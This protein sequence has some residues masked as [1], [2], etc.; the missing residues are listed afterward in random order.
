[1]MPNQTS[2]LSRTVFRRAALAAVT[3]AAVTVTGLGLEPARGPD[4]RSP[5]PVAVG[6]PVQTEAEALTVARQSG[7]QVEV[8]GMRTERREILAAPDGTFTAREYTEPVHA[9]QGGTWVDVDKTLVKRKDGSVAPKA[10]TVGLVFSGGEAGKPFVTMRRG[11]HEMALTWPYGKLTAPVLDG[12]TATYADALPGVDL[13]VRAESDGFGHLLVVK[14][15]EAAADPRLN[16]LDLGLKAK[17][18]TYKKD[19]AGALTAEDSAVGGTV[20]Q[21]GRATMW[22]S[23]GVAETKAVG[24]GATVGGKGPKAAADAVSA[25]RADAPAGKTAPQA[26]EPALAGPEGGGRA[27]DIGVELSKDKLTLIPDQNLLKDGATVFPVVI[28]PIA[29]TLNRSSWTAV[30]SG[31]PDFGEYRYGGS[32]GVGLCPIN[33]NHATCDG[34]GKRRVMYEMPLS[35]Y[36]GKQILGATFSARVEHVYWADAK[37]EPIQ[38]YRVGDGNSHVVS[39]S[40]WRNSESVWSTHLGTVNEK[41]Q[42]TSCGSQANLHF[43]S[44]AN[45]ALA[46]D[47]RSALNQGWDS[48]ILGLKAQD[49]TDYPGW[50]R[51]CGN[52]Y[53]TMSYNNLPGKIQPAQMNSNPGG[54]CVVGAG[55]P[56]VDSAPRLEAIANDRDHAGGQTDQVAVRFTVRYIEGG[57]GKQYTYTTPYKAPTSTTRFSHDARPTLPE[58]ITTWSVATYDGDGWGPESGFCEFVIDKTSPGPPNVGSVQYPADTTYHDGVGTPGSFTFSPNPNDSIPDTD[59]VEYGYSFDAV[60]DKRM[61]NATAGGPVTVSWTPAGA[62]PH[63][64]EV[65]AY[66]RA[67]RASARAHYNF[68]VSAGAPVTAQWNLSDDLGTVA[69]EEEGKYPASYGSGVKLGVDGPGGKIDSAARFD[70]TA[71]AYADAS[72]AVLDTAKSFSVS[73]WVKPSNLGRNLTAVSQ[74]GVGTPGFVLGYDAVAKTWQFSTPSS[75]VEALGEWKALATGVTPVKD[76]WVLLTGVYD[77]KTGKQQ[78][79]VGT[80]LKGEVQRRSPWSSFGTLQIGRSIAKTGYENAFEGDLAQIRVFDRILV[81]GQLSDMIKIKPE[82]KG[83]WQLNGA[84]SGVSPEI[85][86]GQ[87]LTLAGNAA[88]FVENPDPFGDGDSAMVGTGHLNLDGNGDYVSAATAPVTGAVSF[89]LSARVRLSV[90][91]STAS[92]TVFSLPGKNANRVQVRYQGASKLWELVVAG[93]DTT[94]ATKKSFVDTQSLPDDNPAGQ[95]LAVVYDAFAG[96]IKLYVEGQLAASASGLDNTLWA[97]TGGLQVGRSALGSPEYFAGSIDEVR[98]YNGALDAQAVS[99]LANVS[100][101]TD[102]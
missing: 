18:L 66:D 75:D 41:I 91:D 1:M 72:S 93:T 69:K 51:V 5:E 30:M 70:G 77:S 100:E 64:V 23:A 90:K 19:A 3:A 88:I 52:A 76:Q 87:G 101:L 62:G 65:Q 31:K 68:N 61:A 50:K 11:T 24:K 79:Y 49:E 27:S 36:K 28:D 84:T 60:P 98:A 99:Q 10:T 6:T 29:R 78:L 74:D 55:R 73:A 40:S 21:S 32:A 85:A 13:K 16:R 63:W 59:V 26:P 34:I 42:P 46:N 82:R 25:S 37:A 56:V 96:Q 48:M 86:G 35:F 38:L 95:H 97:A 12:D 53:L 2:G 44:A 54:A 67:G 80:E 45:G 47:I 102:R 9:I 4:V 22:D 17:G 43:K 92:Q 20:F 33:Y 57:V 7:K 81:P 39:G 8:L 15:K 58:G 94:T 71:N 83:Y 14:T 89:T